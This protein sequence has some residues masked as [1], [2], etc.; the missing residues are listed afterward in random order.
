MET[1]KESVQA[2]FSGWTYFEKAKPSCVLMSTTTA[3]L[4]GKPCSYEEGVLISNMRDLEYASRCSISA[5]DRRSYMHIKSQDGIRRNKDGQ[6]D[7]LIP[8]FSLDIW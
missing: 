1:A 4:N 5:D 6:R 8:R 7:Y 2:V 3:Q